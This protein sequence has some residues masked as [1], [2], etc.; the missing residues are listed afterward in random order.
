MRRLVAVA[1]ACLFVGSLSA[2]A[3]G[4]SVLFQP[5]TSTS[6]AAGDSILVNLVLDLES[7]GQFDSAYVVFGGDLGTAAGTDLS[8]VPDATWWTPSFDY[9]GISYDNGTAYDQEVLVDSYRDEMSGPL[10]VATLAMGSLTIATTGMMPGNYTVSTY[11]GDPDGSYVIWAF[12]ENPE[13]AS[14]GGSMEFTVLP[15][16][17]VWALLVLGAASMVYRRR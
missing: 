15:E 14:V 11:V 12:A 3:F 1:V 4:A 16:P 6:V 9:T 8:F 5:Q 13:P 17:S 2:P 10:G 7:Y